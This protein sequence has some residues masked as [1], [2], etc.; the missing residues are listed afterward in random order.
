[1]VKMCAIKLAIELGYQRFCKHNVEGEQY[2][3][4]DSCDRV[5]Q[6]VYRRDGG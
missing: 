2:G 5:R 1:M 4:E 3:M 6:R